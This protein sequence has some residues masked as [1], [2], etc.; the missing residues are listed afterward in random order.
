MNLIKK[1]NLKQFTQK[2]PLMRIKPSLNDDLILE[3]Q[4]LFKTKIDNY[5]L[6]NESYK[7]KLIIP[8]NFPKKMIKVFELSSKIPKKSENHVNYDGSFCLGSPLKLRMIINNNN[9]LNNFI[10]K[11]LIPYLY[12]ITLKLKYNQ[13]LIFGELKH[14]EDGILDDYMEIF[15]LNKKDQVKLVWDL[16]ARKKR[17]AN[18][19]NCPCGCNKR[20]GECS[21]R[22]HIYKIKKEISASWIKENNL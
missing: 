21:Y 5:P 11:C 17:A 1:I 3:G 14:G 10:S 20:L 13:T 18:K 12:T 6:V 16:L 2:Q 7:L 9:N 15:K 4:F 22:F 8:K 19:K